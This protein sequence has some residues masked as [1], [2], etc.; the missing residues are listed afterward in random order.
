MLKEM[1]VVAK[2]CSVHPTRRS[3]WS[4]RLGRYV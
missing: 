4:P 3:V 2:E 1:L